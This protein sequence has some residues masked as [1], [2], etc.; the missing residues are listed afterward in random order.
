M[1]D[2]ECTHESWEC[3]PQGW[4]SR[5]TCATGCGFTW[6]SGSPYGRTQQVG[7]C[8]LCGKGPPEVNTWI[9][10]DSGKRE[11]YDSGMRR[12]TQEGKARFDLLL[13]DGIGYGDQFLTRVAGLLERGA[14]KYGE[15]NWQLADSHEEL[16]RFRASALRHLM[17]WACGETDE[18]H[19]AAVV[20]NLMAYESI[21]L[22]LETE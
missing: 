19:A 13:V 10:K 1:D 2:E 3:S 21:K 7:K 11:E 5:H 4:E 12:D 17:Q 20:F 18:D 15:R 8:H 6:S 9:T 16:A 22:K 14:T